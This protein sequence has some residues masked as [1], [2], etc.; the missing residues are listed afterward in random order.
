M[1]ASDV[2]LTFQAPKGRRDAILKLIAHGRGNKEVA[3]T[4]KITERTVNWYVSQF[5]REISALQTDQ[6]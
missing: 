3:D 1:P 5:L 6:N 2:A 4:L